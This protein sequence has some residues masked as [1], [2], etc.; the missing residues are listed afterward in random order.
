VWVQVL[1][2][3]GLQMSP[4]EVAKVHA[5]L[6]GTADGTADGTI[7]MAEFVAWFDVFDMQLEFAR[8]GA[9]GSGAVNRREFMQL[10]ASLG[11]ALTKK[12]RDKVFASL[13]ADG[14]G[15]VTFEEFHPWFRAVRENTKAFVLRA[16]ANWEDE[17][18]LD[19]HDNAEL[20]AQQV[21]ANPN[22][23]PKHDNAELEAQQVGASSP[24][25]SPSVEPHVEPRVVAS[26][27]PP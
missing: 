6:D 7:S 4:D 14:S 19:K 8:F 3:L 10:T 12:E 15:V 24:A 17:L 22:P 18:F 9:N 25:S 20:E 1:R 11:L 16:R 26:R 5:A 27:P 2:E 23:N 21:G 13:D